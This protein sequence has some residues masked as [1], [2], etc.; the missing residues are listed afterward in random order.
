MNGFL[1]AGEEVIVQSAPAGWS[2]TSGDADGSHSHGWWGGADSER[3]LFQSD[4]AFP[5]FIG[6]I[7]NPVLTKD[8]RALTE[9]R[10]LFVQDWIPESNVFLKGGDF[11][12]YGAQVRVAL[13]DR[14]SFIADKDG[15]ATLSPRSFPSRTGSLDIA[16]GLK[17]ALI[18][19]V[20]DQ[21][22]L[23]A[24]FQWEPPTGENKVFQDQGKA[25]IWT[26]FV[27]AGKE[28]GDCWHLMYNG[29]YQFGN[30]EFTS[31]FHYHQL[32]LDKQLFGWLYPLAEVNWFR[33]TH[34]GHYGIPN[35]VGEGDGLINFGTT[36]VAGN[37]LLTAALGVQ[38][39]F[40]QHLE[41]GFAWETPISD[42]KDLI[43]QRVLANMIVRY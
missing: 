41:L 18:R 31:S 25:G 42:R 29:G 5:N 26:V 19:D 20:E 14:L 10:F 33:Y 15:F 13:T 8:V 40:S 28:F 3:G 35:I 34:G 6:P 38:A 1:L 30:A 22:L 24:G 11:Q 39:K 7:T 17:Y 4:Q 9:V 43:L 23:N 32:H 36:G 2:P 37:N 21:F 12:V 16:A 27:N